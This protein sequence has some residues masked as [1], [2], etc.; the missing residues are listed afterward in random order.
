M[1]TLVAHSQAEY[2]EAVA[3][4]HWGSR[5]VDEL[6]KYFAEGQWLMEPVELVS[7]ELE[8]DSDRGPVLAAIYDHSAYRDRLGYRRPLDRPPWPLEYRD[9]PA[10]S[11]AES[12]AR[13][14]M[15]EPVA[16]A[17][18]STEKDSAGVRW[19]TY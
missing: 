12:I 7:A 9:S 11:L 15:S 5:V 14:E 8:V 16:P 2:D 4:S 13:Y 18:G 17:D 3:S 6:R 19:W 1:L 10:E